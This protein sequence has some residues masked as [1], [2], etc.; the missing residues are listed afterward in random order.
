LDVNLDGYE[1]LIV[2]NGHAFD[3]QDADAQTRVN[4]YR[5]RLADFKKIRRAIFRYPRLDQKN[6]VFRNE[7]DGRFRRMEDGWGLGETADVSHG[8][9]TGDFDGDGDRDV[10][11]NRLNRPVGIY[12][13]E[14]EAP[15]VAV[16][17]AGR[18]PNTGGIGS[19]VK[20]EPEGGAVPVQE[21]TVIAGGEY[22]SDSGGTLTFATG[23]AE[24]VTIRVR[25]PT[26][27]ETV[28]EGRAGRIYEVRQ[29]GADPE[30]TD[31]TDGEGGRA[32]P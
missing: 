24:E 27:E 26:G 2:S 11:I 14:G 23:E 18:A 10:V 7:G 1:D 5:S 13:N 30:W 32:A 31:D 29:P 25:W 15:R 4:R 3:V 16:R 20:V 28:V 21:A 17:L 9:A 19:K 6:V 8:M 22:V 12:R